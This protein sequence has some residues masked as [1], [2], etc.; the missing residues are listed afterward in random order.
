MLN[1]DIIMSQTTVQEWEMTRLEVWVFLQED[2]SHL[3]WGSDC[4]HSPEAGGL[5]SP[6]QQRDTGLPTGH[7]V[8]HAGLVVLDLYF[9]V[10]GVIIGSK[11]RQSQKIAGLKKCRSQPNWAG[12]KRTPGIGG[13]AEY[14]HDVWGSILHFFIYF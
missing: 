6:G 11:K 4:L 2:F 7:H 1:I 10:E 8:R 5:T 13:M 12:L 9:K 14:K 3:H